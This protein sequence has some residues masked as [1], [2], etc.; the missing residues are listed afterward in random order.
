MDDDRIDQISIE[1][2]HLFQRQMIALQASSAARQAPAE[3]QDYHKRRG[4]ICELCSGLAESRKLF[5][6]VTTQ[7]C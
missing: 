2:G 5:S 3:V 4:R 1:L 7:A 6:S